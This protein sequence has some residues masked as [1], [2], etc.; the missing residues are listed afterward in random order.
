[1]KTGSRIYSPQEFLAS[2]TDGRLASTL[3]LTGMINE[4]ETTE[5]YASF[6]V[7]TSCVNWRKIPTGAIESIQSLGFVTCGDHNHPLVNISL[8]EPQSEEA[9]L[10]ASFATD[11]KGEAHRIINKLLRE[12]EESK[13]AG[14]T[15]AGPHC[16]RCLQFCGTTDMD[17]FFQCAAF[18]MEQMC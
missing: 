15:D 11:M 3:I 18:C 17:V 12:A 5:Q 14:T 1:M 4:E 8:K 2:L 7:G 16:S 10:F 6:A 9:L 13:T